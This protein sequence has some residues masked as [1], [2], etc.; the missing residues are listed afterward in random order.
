MDEPLNA[1]PLGVASEPFGRFHMQGMK[2][3]CSAF[4][5]EANGIHYAISSGDGC[6]NGGFVVDVAAY[7][8]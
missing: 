5:I 1:C 8:L 3:L 4:A 6:C 7:P 2:C